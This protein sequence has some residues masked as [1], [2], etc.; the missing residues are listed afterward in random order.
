MK[1]FLFFLILFAYGFSP[2]NMI[3]YSKLEFLNMFKSCHL[4]F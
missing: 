1:M 2:S 4:F 3:V